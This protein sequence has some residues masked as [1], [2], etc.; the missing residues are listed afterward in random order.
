MDL[1]FT[2]V[3]SSLDVAAVDFDRELASTE[4]YSPSQKA[5]IILRLVKSAGARLNLSGFSPTAQTRLAKEY[6]SLGMI[7]DGILD[8]VT[9]E[10]EV[11]IAK[12][13][14]ASPSQVGAAL[15]DLEDQIE[16][17]LVQRMRDQHGVRASKNPWEE[18]AEK[19]NAELAKILQ[20]EHPKIISSVLSK[21]SPEKASGLIS[22]FP[23]EI[24]SA[25]TY[26]ISEV[27]N[28]PGDII[29]Q[30]GSAILAGGGKPKISAF[31]GQPVDIIAGILNASTASQR[32]GIL[33]S[34]G[35]LDAD[36]A[37]IVR[38][39]I[40][41]FGD[42]GTRLDAAAVPIFTRAVPNDIL[43]TA[44]AAAQAEM[45]E[46]VE[47]ILGSMSSRMADQ[48][49]EEISERGE[50]ELADGEDAMMQLTKAIGVLKDQG[51]IDYITSDDQAED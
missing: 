28:A 37:K 36:F 42:I 12:G 11:Q 6:I 43:I 5:A 18:I 22:V 47:F 16:Q 25:A 50:V 9:N 24:S 29:D 7:D 21:L 34:L 17:G 48:L 49:R 39:A 40:F 44:L 30:I 46:V 14:T 38:E 41:T 45:G 1:A 13:G 26:A 33:E 31:D 10:L 32:D 4:G 19:P 35:A 27:E 15:N 3:P 8:A 23:E 20:N 2:P 51:E